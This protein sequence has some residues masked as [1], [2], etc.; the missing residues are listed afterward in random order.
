PAFGMLL[1]GTLMAKF[2]WRPF[3][4]S[5]GV[6]SLLW[7]VPWI[8]WMPRGPSVTPAV[9]NVRSPSTLEILKQRSAWTSFA[10]LFCS[11]YVTYFLLSWL[12]Y[13]LVRERNFSMDSMA[14][15]GGALYLTQAL[16]AVVCGWIADKLIS[17]GK[18]PSVH[19]T[20]MVIG[21]IGTATFLMASS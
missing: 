9:A 8:R 2:G 7:L 4:V 12:P 3:F 14:K 6:I 5:V 21:L 15:I 13:Y 10:A 19:K 11:T 1:G 20:F 16:C 18:T 17:W